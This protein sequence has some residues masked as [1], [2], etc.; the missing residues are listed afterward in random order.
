MKAETCEE[1]RTYTKIL[2]MDKDPDAE[3]FADD[4]AT[5]ALDILVGEAGWTRATANP[6]LVPAAA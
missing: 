1:C 6:F 4:L 2:Y 3:P 5:L